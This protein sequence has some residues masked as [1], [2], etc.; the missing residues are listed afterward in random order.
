MNAE[1]THE[2]YELMGIKKILESYRGGTYYDSLNKYVDTRI[3]EL[4]GMEPAASTSP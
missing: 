4:L 1:I 2:L 3:M